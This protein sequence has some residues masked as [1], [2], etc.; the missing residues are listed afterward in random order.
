MNKIQLFILI[1]TVLL[2]TTDNRHRRPYVT[3]LKINN[4]NNNNNNQL[5]VELLQQQPQQP[6]IQHIDQTIEEIE[7]VL[8][9]D[10]EQGDV[11]G[12]IDSD[13]PSW[14]PVAITG[15]SSSSSSSSNQHAT[16]P[17]P[18]PEGL[19]SFEE[20]ITSPSYFSSGHPLTSSSGSG[21]SG[22]LSGAP[23]ASTTATVTH[24][25]AGGNGESGNEPKGTIVLTSTLD[26]TFISGISTTLG[27]HGQFEGDIPGI[28][29]TE[30]HVNADI[31]SDAAA[32]SK[33][34]DNKYLLVSFYLFT[35]RKLRRQQIYYFQLLSG[36]KS[37]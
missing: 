37:V 21:S 28:G 12:D 14:N 34:T 18:P 31:E 23:K 29:D 36:L 3:A 2:V 6:Q 25:A 8:A 5:S 22:V 19:T 30:A 16:P 10:Q 20:T 4:N 9:A 32:S 17:P 7:E 11:L 35:F 27:M 1:L 24:H 33:S 13:I 15:G 26:P